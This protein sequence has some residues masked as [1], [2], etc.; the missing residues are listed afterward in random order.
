[1]FLVVNIRR[2]EERERRRQKTETAE[3]EKAEG[4]PVSLFSMTN[5]VIKGDVA[6]VFIIQPAGW[7]AASSLLRF[8]LLGGRNLCS[9][10]LHKS[11]AIP[12]T[13]HPQ[14]FGEAERTVASKSSEHSS[15]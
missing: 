12:M 11:F 4:F 5:C 14:H 1:M 10:S 13:A 8:S 2:R 3:E 6:E 9:F 15:F 7:L